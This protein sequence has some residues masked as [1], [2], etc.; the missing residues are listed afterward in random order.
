MKPITLL[1]L[2][3]CDTYLGKGYGV[4]DLI[5]EGISE[6]LLISTCGGRG[7]VL[8]VALTPAGRDLLAQSSPEDLGGPDASWNRLWAYLLAHGGSKE[9][10]YSSLRPDARIHL[11]ECGL[12]A[13]ASTMPTDDGWTEFAGTFAEDDRYSGLSGKATCRCGLVKGITIYAEYPDLSLAG[14]IRAATGDW[15]AFVR[16]VTE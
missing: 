14:M 12:D 10:E 9:N 8:S 11:A 1:A 15:D 4:Q 2:A 7:D 6:G 16:G 3:G 13:A 5:G